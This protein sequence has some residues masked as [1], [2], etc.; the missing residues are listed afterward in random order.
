VPDA[1]TAS[2]IRAGTVM[3][4]GESEE[5]L[6]AEMRALTEWFGDQVRVEP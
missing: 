6:A 1:R 2:N 5:G 3:M 4:S